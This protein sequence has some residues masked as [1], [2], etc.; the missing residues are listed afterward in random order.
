[1]TAK[2]P[3]FLLLAVG[4]LTAR[5]E[6]IHLE[7]ERMTFVLP[8]GWVEI[9]EQIRIQRMAEI[10]QSLAKPRTLK[11]THVFQPSNVDWFS[12]PI[13]HSRAAER[14]EVLRGGA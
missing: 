1:M 4:P 8:D 13:H 6:T 14:S 9:P 5:A 7:A 2:L 3:L 11:Y 10:E 12:Y